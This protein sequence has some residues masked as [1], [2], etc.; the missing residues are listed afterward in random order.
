[1][2]SLFS[3][4][5]RS[6]HTDS[7]RFSL[8]GL[9]FASILLFSWIHWFFTANI[10]LYKTSQKAHVTSAETFDVEFFHD[11]GSEVRTR[12]IRWRGVEA[13][14]LPE[15]LGIIRKGQSAVLKIAD[16]TGKMS[17]SVPA[18]VTKVVNQPWKERVRVEL[19]AKFDSALS[20]RV[21]PGQTG[22]INIEVEHVLPVSFLMRLSGMADHSG[23]SNS[24][25]RKSG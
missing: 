2:S 16:T 11:T 6:L 18:I 14:F 1:M 9:I 12:E 25:F 21:K 7:F 19:R 10:P 3:R 23:S 13:E 24:G 17:R 4:T 15:T 20:A 8:A 5:V 22:N